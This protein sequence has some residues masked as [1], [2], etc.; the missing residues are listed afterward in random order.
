MA[1]PL[2]SPVAWS[3]RLADGPDNRTGHTGTTS[4]GTPPC[5]TSLERTESARRS[6]G[7]VQEGRKEEEQEHSGEWSCSGCVYALV[8]NRYLAS[9]LGVSSV[10]LLRCC[11]IIAIRQKAPLLRYNFFWLGS[12]LFLSRRRIIIRPETVPSHQ[13]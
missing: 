12:S 13:K 4:S 10:L 3:G 11:V 1:C 7:G 8:E 2:I 5:Y 9:T 6:L